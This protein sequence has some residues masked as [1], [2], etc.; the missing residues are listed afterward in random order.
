MVEED[1]DGGLAGGAAA[2]GGRGLGCGAVGC[3][4]WDWRV[5]LRRVQHMGNGGGWGDG[6]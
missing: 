2:E 3:G 4:I 1:G 5:E 6:V